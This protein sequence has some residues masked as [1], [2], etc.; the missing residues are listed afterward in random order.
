MFNGWLFRVLV[1]DALSDGYLYL[2]E[3]NSN[4]IYSNSKYILVLRI[5]IWKIDSLKEWKDFFILFLEEESL[6]NNKNEKRHKDNE[7]VFPILFTSR[8]FNLNSFF[9][10]TIFRID[11]YK[12]FP[13]LLLLISNDIFSSC[14]SSPIIIISLTNLSICQSKAFLIEKMI[15]I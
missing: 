7:T 5:Y 13:K 15:K 9:H 8:K 12:I 11:L 3:L 1:E 2:C 10:V 6:R 14:S 4:V